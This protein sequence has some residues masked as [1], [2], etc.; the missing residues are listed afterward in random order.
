[1]SS[2][3]LFTGAIALLVLAVP[4]AASADDTVQVFAGAQFDFSNYVFAGAT[5]ALPGQSVD[6]GFSLRG[7]VD[8]GGYNYMRSRLGVVNATFSGGEFDAVYALT[9]SHFWNELGV[10]ANYTY[11]GLAPYD[12]KNDLRGAQTELHASLDGG[13]AG[14]PWRADWN[15]YYGTRLEDYA[16]MVGVT[17]AITSK[18]RLGIEGAGTGNPNYHLRQAGPYAGVSFDRRSELQFSAGEAWETGFTPRA[19]VGAIFFRRF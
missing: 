5:V 3:A 14:G 7:F 4:V 2:R 6:N 15:G 18:W 8:S 19:Y 9:R 10:G 12:V 13:A 16:A 17:H 11:T 1:M